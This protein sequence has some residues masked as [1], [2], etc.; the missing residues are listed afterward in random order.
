M[1]HR[2]NNCEDHHFKYPQHRIPGDLHI[3]FLGTSKLSF[4]ERD[5]KFKEEDIISIRCANFT[6]PLVN[7]VSVD[8]IDVGNPIV[9]KKG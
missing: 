1:S 8:N 9:V 7:S 4:G 5:W 6:A 2:L 3:H